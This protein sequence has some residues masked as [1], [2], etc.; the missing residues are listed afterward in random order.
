MTKFIFKLKEAFQKGTIS[1][2]LI[3]VNAAVF[4]ITALVAVFFQLFNKNVA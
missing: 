3:Y 1:F 4:L 2:R